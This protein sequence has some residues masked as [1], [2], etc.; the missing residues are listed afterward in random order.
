MSSVICTVRPKS[1]S[2][3][4]CD[5]RTMLLAKKRKRGSDIH[6]LQWYCFSE[7][8]L[9]IVCSLFCFAMQAGV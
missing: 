2:T 1:T 5:I 8:L 9:C 7:K 6:V 4:L 3:A